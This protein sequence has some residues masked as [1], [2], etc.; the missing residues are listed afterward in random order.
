MQVRRP[1]S[2]QREVKVPRLQWGV[3][4]RPETRSF[5]IGDPVVG[6][7]IGVLPQRP[8]S[9]PAS[10]WASRSLSFPRCETGVVT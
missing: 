2:G 10:R 7:Q 9:P 8:L 3:S 5:G 6:A 1:V 4:C